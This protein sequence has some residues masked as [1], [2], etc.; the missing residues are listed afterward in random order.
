MLE[1]MAEA[2]S[3]AACERAG[4]VLLYEPIVRDEEYDAALAY[5]AR[6]LEE[7]AGS[8]NFL[9]SFLTR[10]DG[11]PLDGERRRF[12]AAVHARQSVSTAPRRTQDRRRPEPAP[13][14]FHNEADTDWTQSANR[15]WLATAQASPP[16]AADPAAIDVAAVE[17]AV[18]RARAAGAQW[19]ARPIAERRAT[20]LAVAEAMVAARGTTLATMARVAVKTIG[21]GDPEV[22]EAIDFARYYADRAVEIDRT[23]ARS[24]AH[25]RPLGT[26]VVAPP[27]NFPYSIPAGGVLAALAAGNAVI[28]K[29]APEA[30]DVAALVARH[31]WAGGVPTDV[32]QF[33]PCDDD[34]AGRRLITHP[35]V[36]AVILTG[37]YE[38]AAA[39]LDWRPDLHLVAETSG[40]NAIVI[41]A[42][43]DLD[44][45][46]RDLVHS[47]FGHAGQKCSAASLAIVEASVHDDPRF[48]ERLADA[49][50]SLRLGPADD[51]ATDMAPLLRPAGGPLLRALTRLE[52]GERWLVE[53]RPMDESGV[54]WSPGVRLGVEPGSWF[55]VTECFGPVLGVLRAP[56]LEHAIAWQNMAPFGLTGGIHSLDPAEV[57][58]WL[59]AVEVGN[60]YVNRGITGAVVRR[61]PFGGWK[62]SAV[63]STA[64]AGGP[65]YV[66]SLGHWSLDPSRPG[67]EAAALAAEWAAMQEGSD[68]SALRAERN[69]LR[70]RPLRRV[71]L[72]AGDDVDDRELAA[73]L[74][75]ARATGTQVELSTSGARSSAAGVVQVVE[76]EQALGARLAPLAAA[77]DR[78]RLLGT[79]GDRLLAAL[80]AAG[81]SVDSTPAIAVA[82]LELVHWS[83]AQAISETR[84]RHGHVMRG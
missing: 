55:H 68:P 1:G 36:D 73:A 40:K 67:D 52:P 43:A 10:G 22:S 53:P 69:L 81:A 83:R 82:H 27:W 4:A 41:T 66:A 13:G 79:V 78:V 23:C 19:A 26:V 57:E 34:D 14:S 59:E 58:R 16:A 6:R 75:A 54:R 70:Y 76:D 65:D 15:E 51:L 2:S 46:I 77:F 45:A 33:L 28:L 50:E 31:C 9:R 20:L 64:K 49:V 72:R 71:L 44:L 7:N 63:G 29:P 3:E 80:H 11:D 25:F 24:G 32:L 38:T 18:A 47:A 21:E 48:L 60:A 56:D 30:R 42:C 37:S 35:D 12:V 17:E 74:G 39:F 5:L 84:H 61:Q 8:D 62:R